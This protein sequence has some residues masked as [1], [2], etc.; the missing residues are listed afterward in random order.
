MND[1]PNT[2]NEDIGSVQGME[3]LFQ[4]F[5][6]HAFELLKIHLALSTESADRV[7]LLERY[8]CL[9]KK[10]EDLANRYEKATEIAQ[11]KGVDPVLIDQAGE[12]IRRLRTRLAAANELYAKLKAKQA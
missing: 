3:Q 5:E 8:H 2:S 11:S 1:N 4:A 10:G 6:E 9:A 12:L 7:E